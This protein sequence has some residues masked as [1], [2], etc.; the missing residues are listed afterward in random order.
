MSMPPNRCA[1]LSHRVFLCRPCTNLPR[2]SGKRLSDQE[3]W[4]GKQSRTGHHR[5]VLWSSAWSHTA[6]RQAAQLEPPLLA[7][8]ELAA[9]A[10]P[11]CSS[12]PPVAAGSPSLASSFFSSFFFS[13]GFFAGAG[14]AGLMG[15]FSVS[16][17][18]SVMLTLSS[19]GIWWT[20]FLTRI[21][22]PVLL[23]PSTSPFFFVPFP[24]LY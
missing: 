22:R 19:S 11:L 8:L 24:I 9:L 18:V 5:F 20:L 17:Q 10:G 6:A 14:L 23:P 16:V 2:S 1:L 7:S 3:G 4:R 12:A 15:I 13:S 21:T